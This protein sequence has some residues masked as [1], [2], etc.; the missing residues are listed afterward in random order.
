MSC[1]PF[2]A[3]PPSDEHISQEDVSFKC[4]FPDNHLSRE[5]LHGCNFNASL[6]VCMRQ[7]ACSQ[8]VIDIPSA[9]EE[10][11]VDDDEDDDTAAAAA[12]SV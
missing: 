8:P 11:E 9:D 7:R 2:T 12:A 5:R 1:R 4:Q 10:A 3:M 6:H